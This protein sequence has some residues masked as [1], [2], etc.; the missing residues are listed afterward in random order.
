MRTFSLT[1][2]LLQVNNHM[3]KQLVIIIS[4]ITLVSC[5]YKGPLVLPK[6]TNQQVATPNQFA[7]QNFGNES[8]ESSILMTNESAH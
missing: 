7:P 3:I 4:I 6:Q 5:G 1:A 8:Q 2:L